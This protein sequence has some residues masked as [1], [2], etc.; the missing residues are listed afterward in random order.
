MALLT[1]ISLEYATGLCRRNAVHVLKLAWTTHPDI[2]FDRA[3][4]RWLD[5]Y[6]E[7]SRSSL[8]G[9]LQHEF[10]QFM[11]CYYGQCLIAT[12]GGRWEYSVGE[13]GIR[14]DRFGVTYPFVAVARQIDVG[15]AASVAA[16]FQAATDCLAEAA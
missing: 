15:S 4:V 3:G 7:D 5:Q 13:L 1:D 12:F 9:D 11:G 10:V 8:A 6:I 16:S 2:G 14:M